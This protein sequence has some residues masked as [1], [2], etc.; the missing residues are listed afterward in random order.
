LALGDFVSGTGDHADPWTGGGVKE[1]ESQYGPAAQM[2]RTRAGYG[3]S[4]IHPNLCHE[5]DVI[6]GPVVS[7]E[8]VLTKNVA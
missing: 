8:G 6:V 5:M 3:N 4:H 2:A 7:A 1:G